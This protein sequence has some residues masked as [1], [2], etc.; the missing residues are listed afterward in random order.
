ML[1]VNIIYKFL[2]S[3]SSLNSALTTKQDSL[4]LGIVATDLDSVDVGCCQTNTNTSHRPDTAANRCVV[5]TTKTFMN[6]Y[7]FA[8]Q[9]AF[10]HDNSECYIRYAWGS[11]SNWKT[12]I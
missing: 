1:L 11:W 2:F 7:N 5:F 4:D 8:L 9:I 6:G 10:C 12:L 3:F